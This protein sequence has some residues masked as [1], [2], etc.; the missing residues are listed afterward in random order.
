MGER[1]H[2]MGERGKDDGCER[3]RPEGKM[4]GARRSLEHGGAYWSRARG[5]ATFHVSVARFRCRRIVKRA[6]KGC[7]QPIGLLM[8]TS[9]SRCWINSSNISLKRSKEKP[10]A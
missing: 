2:Q 7:L 9:P 6:F 10:N 1:Y 4:V 3:S 5:Q 8:A